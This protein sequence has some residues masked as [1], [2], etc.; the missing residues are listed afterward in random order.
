MTTSSRRDVEGQELEELR[1]DAAAWREHVARLPVRDE[2][3]FSTISGTPARAIGTASS[4][5]GSASIT[6]AIAAPVPIPALPTATAAAI[7]PL[8]ARHA[9]L[10]R[11]RQHRLVA[12]RIAEAGAGM[13]PAPRLAG[14]EDQLG[15]PGAR[16]Q[17]R[18]N[19]PV[20][21]VP[22]RRLAEGLVLE[23]PGEAAAGSGIRPRLARTPLCDRTP[24]V[25]HLGT[26]AF[27]AA[28]LSACSE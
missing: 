1:R 23:E 24:G 5:Q 16:Q 26:A 21:A 7:Q 14:M 15:A 12:Q 3:D 20:E 28:S 17:Q 27:N 4:N 9:G 22:E 8:R 10:P 18:R 11:S 2:T 13:V 19:L 6:V 25:P